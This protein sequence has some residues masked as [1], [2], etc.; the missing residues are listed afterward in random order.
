MI[1]AIGPV[2]TFIAIWC[3]VAFAVGLVVGPWISLGSDE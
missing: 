1:S 2:F 3:A